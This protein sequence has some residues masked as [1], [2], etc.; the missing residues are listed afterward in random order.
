MLLLISTVGFGWYVYAES[1]AIAEATL[2]GSQNPS[3]QDDV[4]SFYSFMQI[5]LNVIG[6][7]SL[8][9]SLT[10]LIFGIALFGGRRVTSFAIFAGAG[11]ILISIYSIVFI[12]VI[13]ACT[14]IIYNS[15]SSI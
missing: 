7:L 12:V 8:L 1:N 4:L 3:L 5:G 14:A 10:M 15:N 13:T 6:V 2:V 11:Y 9:L